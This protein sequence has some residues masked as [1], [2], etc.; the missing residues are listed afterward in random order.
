MKREKAYRAFIEPD[1][2]L[3]NVRLGNFVAWRLLA[4]QQ[5]DIFVALDCHLRLAISM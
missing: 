1:A 3:S 4:G 5:A 2:L